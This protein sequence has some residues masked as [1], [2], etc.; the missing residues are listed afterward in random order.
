MFKTNTLNFHP[1]EKEIC[2]K[3]ANYFY[4]SIVGEIVVKSPYGGRLAVHEITAITITITNKHNNV[5][6]TT[7]K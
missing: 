1:S 5:N 6:N 7:N 3:Q 2:L 4:E